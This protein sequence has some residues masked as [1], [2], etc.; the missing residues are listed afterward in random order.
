MEESAEPPPW[1]V[2]WVCRLL[3]HLRRSGIPVNEARL[4]AEKTV[5]VS[6]ESHLAQAEILEGLLLAWPGVA[7]VERVGERVLRARGSSGLPKRR[8]FA[9]W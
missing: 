7:T 4:T 1:D 2:A 8:R 6:F 3:I 9:W 5:S